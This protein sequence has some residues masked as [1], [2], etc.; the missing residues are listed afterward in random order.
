MACLLDVGWA[1]SGLCRWLTEAVAGE[2]I[3][4]TAGLLLI[5]CKVRGNHA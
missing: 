4:T 5:G 3:G 1:D 2:T